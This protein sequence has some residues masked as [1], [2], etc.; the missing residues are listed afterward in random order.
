M[1]NF[2]GCRPAKQIKYI[3]NSAYE[4]KK[5]CILTTSMLYRNVEEMHLLRE[6]VRYYRA[7]FSAD[8]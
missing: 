1:K 8:L 7:R 5:I 6:G 3:Q 4:T 2:R